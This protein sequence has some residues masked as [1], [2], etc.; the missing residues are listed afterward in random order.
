MKPGSRQRTHKQQMRKR[1][2]GPRY[3]EMAM[4]FWT[5]PTCRTSLWMVRRQSKGRARQVHLM[6]GGA[7][8]YSA[9]STTGKS[10][11]L[12]QHPS[13]LRQQRWQREACT[14]CSGAARHHLLVATASCPAQ[15]HMQSGCTRAPAP[16]S[17]T[18]EGSVTPASKSWDG[19][20]GL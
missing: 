17:V 8:T 15:P 2:A 9:T 11:E 20:G 7:G 16:G 6:V 13:V 12:W 4:S 1:R 18:L 3:Q 14:P 10:R 19:P 5:G